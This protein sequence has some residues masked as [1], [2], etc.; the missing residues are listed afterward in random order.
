[1]TDPALRETPVTARTAFT[2]TRWLALIIGIAVGLRLGL[3]L[4]FKTHYPDAADYDAL[5]RA[6]L[7]GRPYE[8]GGNIASRMPGYPLFVAAI[9]AIA[10]YSERAVLIAQALLA[11]P[12][13]AFTYLIGRRI[14]R[15]TGLLAA[16][17]VALDPLTVGFSAAPLSETPFTLCL[18]IAVW[19]AIK[20][21]ERPGWSRWI[22]LGL[23]WGVAVL[24]RGSAL[25]CIVPLAAMA[26]LGRRGDLVQRIA[27]PVVAI[28]LTF[29][30]L[31]PWLARNY[32]HFHSGPLRLTTLQ[33]ISLYEAVYP[34]ADG[35]PRQHAIPLP[36]AMAPLDEAQRNDEWS[37]L[38]WKHIREDPARILRLA[39]IKFART[40][41]PWFNAAEMQSP[42]LWW[43]MVLWSIP[44][45][46]LALLG[47]F[48]MP[49][50]WR[51]KGIL[52]VPIV[53]FSLLHS[54]FLGSVRYRVP[55]MP[56]VCIFAA[57]GIARLANRA[58]ST[59]RPQRSPEP[60]V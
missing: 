48:V 21:L 2:S 14:S 29:A 54:V 4:V 51:H 34:E 37:R 43:G 56:I 27:G 55:L 15:S 5:A 22:A 19:L 3:A 38:A 28:A 30:V 39:P 58:I 8:V 26:A 11:I 45:F 13:L 46:G 23:T 41:S 10:G 36:P 6:L 57:G 59:L 31:T 25:W 32:S 33:G 1:M 12:M 53:Y 60:E 40:W 49:L 52:L 42:L 20:L 7:E 35:G 16:A 24:M 18:L 9:Y 47:I 17:L 44:L 50:S